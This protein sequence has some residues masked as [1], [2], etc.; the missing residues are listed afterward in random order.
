VDALSF[1]ADSLNHSIH[2][3]F[4]NRGGITAVRR[5]SSGHPTH[6][7]WGYIFSQWTGIGLATLLKLP[8]VPAKPSMWLRRRASFNLFWGSA[9][10]SK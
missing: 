4:A 8:H 1:V 10:S 3:A 2:L 5:K 6:L 9:M 7:D